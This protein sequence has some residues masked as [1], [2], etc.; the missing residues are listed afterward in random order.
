MCSA[1]EF[2]TCPT[3]HG[4][5]FEVHVLSSVLHEDG[6]HKNLDCYA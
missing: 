4:F 6:E 1:R 5:T 2:S 3:R